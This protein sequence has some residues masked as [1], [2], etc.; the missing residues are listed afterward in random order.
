M[1]N[2]KC[3]MKNR[4]RAFTLIEM[5]IILVILGLLIG[6][7]MPLLFQ[8]TKHQHYRSTQKDLEGIGEALAGYAGIHGKLPPADTNGDGVGDANQTSG[9]LPYLDLGLGAVDSWRTRYS[10]DVNS[11]LITT[12]TLSGLCTAISSIVAGEFPQLAFSSGGGTTAQAFVVLSAGENSAL[13]GGNTPFPGDRRYESYSPTDTFD[14]LVTALDPNALYARL[15]CTSG[16]GTPACPSIAVI[17]RRGSAIRVRGGTYLSCTTVNNN[18]SFTISTGQTINIYTTAAN[19]TNGT[20]PSPITY[21]GATA[22][23]IDTDCLVR[24]TATG[25]LDE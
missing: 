23:D 17:N 15:G 8:M 19:C 11:R 14:D 21:S 5:A 24:W 13:N 2:V 12:S 3:K 7:T 1:Q 16:G 22:A 4:L 6:A 10:Y 18:A 9:T 20:S 25:L